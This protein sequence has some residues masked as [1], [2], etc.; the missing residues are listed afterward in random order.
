MSR[1]CSTPSGTFR[2]IRTLLRR[3]WIPSLIILSTVGKSIVLLQATTNANQSSDEARNILKAIRADQGVTGGQVLMGG[4]TAV[5]VDVIRFI[6]N[7]VPL[8]V[9]VVVVAS[10]PDQTFTPRSSP[11]SES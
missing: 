8:A 11:R 10:S 3:E 4:A 6:Y 2:H 5:D 7:Q 9:S 1:A